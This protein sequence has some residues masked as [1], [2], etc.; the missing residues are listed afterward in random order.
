MRTRR[1]PP[2][3]RAGGF[4]LIE[5]LVALAIVAIA[6]FPMLQIVGEAQ[7]DTYD[8]KFATLCA[9]RMRSLL[10]EIT[11]SA[12]PG[13]NSSG[14]FSTMTDEEGYDS[15]FAYADIRFEWQCQ[16]IDLSLDVTPAADLSEDKKKERQERDKKQE[17]KKE[18]EDE[19]AA[20][21]TRYRARYVKISCTYRLEDNE[22]RVLL[23]ETYV[24]PLP[25]ADQLKK[26]KNGRDEVPPNNGSKGAGAKS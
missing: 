25:T 9:G 14:D 24:P 18:A 11:R 13:S 2:R 17:E 21:E 7:K 5:V 15:R 23:I 3:I 6:V 1:T 16:S 4:T 8:S 22:E 12:K 10:A 26:G 19:D 20:I